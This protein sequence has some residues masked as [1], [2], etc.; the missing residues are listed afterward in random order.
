MYPR[1]TASLQKLGATNVE[2]GEALEVSYKTIERYIGGDIPEPLLKLLR[3]PQ[4]LRDL[5]DD[6]EALLQ[7]DKIV[8][9]AC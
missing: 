3:Q 8:A 9:Q 7:D 6:A 4:L 5:A 2:R 1:F